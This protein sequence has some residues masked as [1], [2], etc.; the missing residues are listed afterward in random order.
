MARAT[1]AATTFF[2]SIQVGRDQIEFIDAGLGYNNPCEILIKEAQRQ[3]PNRGQMQVLSIGTG[4]GDVLTISSSWRSIISALKDMATS[5]KKVAGTLDDKYGESGQYYR[6]NVEDGLRDVT[7]SDWEKA[8][9]ISSHTANYL[10]ENKKKIDKFVK[11]FARNAQDRRATGA[12]ELSST[13]TR[14]QTRQMPAE[15]G[16]TSAC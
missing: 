16:E 15:L 14:E 11:G 5:S 7:L 3:F 4:L 6:F 9:T 1:S 10:S 12:Q 13:T 8:S 2:K